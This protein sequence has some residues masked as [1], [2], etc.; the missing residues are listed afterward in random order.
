MSVERVGVA[1]E[2]RF[3][4]KMNGGFWL[5]PWVTSFDFWDCQ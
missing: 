4:L 5:I 2:V 1:P 3:G